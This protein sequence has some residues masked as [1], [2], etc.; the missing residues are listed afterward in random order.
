MIHLIGDYYAEPNNMGFT[1]VKDNGAVD[2]KGN[3]IYATHGYY[4]NFE[5]VI[6][7]L[8]RKVVGDR[9]KSQDMELSEAIR[10][11]RETTDEIKETMKGIEV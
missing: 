8:K 11:I 4:G 9:L 5:E 2:K 10:V 6:F 3:K 7:A 1:L